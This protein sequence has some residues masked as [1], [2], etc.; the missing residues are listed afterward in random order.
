MRAEASSR[1]M[2]L[3]RQAVAEFESSVYD[4]DSVKYAYVQLDTIASGFREHYVQLFSEDDETSPDEVF[5][6]LVSLGLDNDA[7]RRARELAKLASRHWYDDNRAD[8]MD[9]LAEA[10][11]HR[12]NLLGMLE[13]FLSTDRSRGEPLPLFPETEGS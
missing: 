12:E 3:I 1:P 2:K 8:E 13:S 5:E 10:E 7:P 6:K 11:E 9:A 4:S